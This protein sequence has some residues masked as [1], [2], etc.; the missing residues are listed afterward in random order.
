MDDSTQSS[1]RGALKFL[2]ILRRN[3]LKIQCFLKKRHFKKTKTGQKGTFPKRTETGPKRTF[4]KQNT[5]RTKKHI[6]IKDKKDKNRAVV[7]LYIRYSVNIIIL[8]LDSP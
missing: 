6:S 5:N 7:T 4:Q 8:G 1:P 3:R 2:I